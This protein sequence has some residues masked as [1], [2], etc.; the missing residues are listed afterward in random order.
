MRRRRSR[1]ALI[2]GLGALLLFGA[3]V[4]AGFAV[5]GQA[6]PE[7]LRAAV[8]ASLS[9]ALATKAAVESVRLVVLPDIIVEATGVTAFPGANGPALS[10]GR[11][12]ATLDPAALVWGRVRFRSIALDGAQLTLIRQRDGQW[13]PP[14][15]TPGLE[16]PLDLFARLFAARLPTPALDVRSGSVTVT[17]LGSPATAGGRRFEVTDLAVRMLGSRLLE[18]GRLR[19]VGTLRQ[20]KPDG[21]RFE[22]DVTA[23]R[24]AAPRLE[25]AVADLD[26]AR[27]TPYLRQQVAGLEMAGLVSGVLAL[28]SG[29]AGAAD[30]A[31][32]L[33]ATGLRAHAGRGDERRSLPGPLSAGFEG[34]LHVGSASLALSDARLRTDDLELAGQASIERP[35]GDEA[36]L[37]LEG[38]AS[39]LD[40]AALRAAGNWLAPDERS[41]FEVAT[42]SLVSGRL[43][44]LSLAG[45][46]LLGAWRAAARADGTWL[47]AGAHLEA[48]VA[49]LVVQPPGGEPV[50]AIRGQVRLDGTGVLGV[51]GLEG[52]IGERA[53]PVLDLRLAG[54]H[55]LLAAA[56]EPVPALA[57]ALPG[58]AALEALVIGPS[59]E[60]PAPAWTAIEVDADWILHPAFFRPLRS[61]KA[62]FEP[63]PSG[64][65][66]R[67]DRGSWGG[68]A[69]RG[70]GS[71][72]MDSPQ[73]VRLSL[74]A[75]ALEAPVGPAPALESWAHG[76]FSVEKPAG[77]G[78]HVAR[79]RGGFDLTGTRLTIFDAS[80]TFGGPG[81]LTGDARL[82]L[83]QAGEVGAQLR[84]GLEQAR[85]PDFLALFSDDAAQSSGSVDASARLAGTLRPGA[86]ILAGLDG[87]ARVTARDGELSI[88]LPLL[89]AIAKAST[90]FNPFGSASGLRFDRIDTELRVEGGRLATKRTISLESPDLR[91]ALSGSVDVRESP[92]RLEAVVG[93]FFLEPLDQVLGLMPFVSRVLL[94]PDRSL[95]GTYFELTGSWESPEAGLLP[96]K[97]IAFGPASF[98]LEDVPAFVRR[99]ITGIQH[100]LL[101]NEGPPAVASPAESADPAGDGS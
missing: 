39:R 8:E 34:T 52:R 24:G 40:V 96:L 70:E 93:C 43:E 92:H 47:P 82:D 53:L 19:A 42:A 86:P 11:L 6:A 26:L 67:L 35:T 45:D 76:R 29:E 54:F 71:L 27:L 61:A 89:L 17:D 66:V 58:R 25:L 4:L 5:A 83:G 63:T 81:R 2:R 31:L 94:G 72:A 51:T 10:A 73:R 20:T 37:A 75:G 30:L 57:P 1:R 48:R 41:A 69:L 90:T 97:T 68:V 12:E 46:A 79:L 55:N 78:L 13:T 33:V 21:M 74:E 9:E 23:P 60:G 56:A 22:L 50:S 98:L 88:D 15:L 28:D 64:V 18:P 49:D 7:R 95:F 65:S 16:N 84:A 36:R 59:G 99:G 38:S 91:L 77:P 80:A 87:D 85:V 100:A 101:G 3:G 14:L 32:D 62:R 44:A